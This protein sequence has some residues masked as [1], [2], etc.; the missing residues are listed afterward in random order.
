M[1]QTLILL[2]GYPGTGKSYLAELL[3]KQFTGFEILSPDEIKEEFWDAYVKQ[4]NNLIKSSFMLQDTIHHTRAKFFA[5]PLASGLHSLCMDS[6]VDLNSDVA[7]EGALDIAFFD[8][9]GFGTVVDSLSAIK[10][11]VFEDK[12]LTMD[13]VIKAIDANFEGY[14][15]V[16]ALLKSAPCYGNNDPYAD[17]IGREIDRHSI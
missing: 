8:A 11:L 9:I 17:S 1:K 12:K 14:E 13:E 7:P 6:C 10:K 4:Q 2:A 5:S 16:K 15:D 3:M